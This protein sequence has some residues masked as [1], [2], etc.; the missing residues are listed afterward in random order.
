MALTMANVPDRAHSELEFHKFYGDD[1]AMHKIASFEAIADFQIKYSRDFYCFGIPREYPVARFDLPAEAMLSGKAGNFEKLSLQ[2]Q[3]GEYLAFQIA[4]WSPQLALGNLCLECG[5]FPLPIRVFVQN[6]EKYINLAAGKIKVYWC[7]IDLP[8]TAGKFSGS[9]TVNANDVAPVTIPCALTVAGEKLA[10]GGEAEDFRMSRLRWLDSE[11][12]ISHEVPVPFTALRREE[13]KI[14]LL[15]RTLTLSAVGLPAEAE[16][17]FTGSNERLC[18]KPMQLLNKPMRFVIDD[19]MQAESVDCFCDFTSENPDRIEWHSGCRFAGIDAE[20]SVNGFIEYDGFAGFDCAIKF[21]NECSVAD[22]RLEFSAPGDG[23]VGLNRHGGK[24][25]EKLLWY[26]DAN[27]GQDAFWLGKLNGGIH[28]R[29]RDRSSITP[30]TNCYYLF[31]KIVPPQA[32]DNGGIGGIKLLRKGEINAINAFSGK[33][34]IPQNKI[35]DFGF[36]MQL[37][38]YKLTEPARHLQQRFFQ[39]YMHDLAQPLEKTFTPE[40]FAQLRSEGV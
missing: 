6:Y 2:G 12:G 24:T 7:M 27:R 34:E 30:L 10:S 16:S 22:I 15:G 3:P 38:P 1:P 37:S 11:I 25:P 31:S 5:G 20:L 36:E 14:F 32:W 13:R 35:F 17:F 33:R 19:G 21:N 26:W 4:V 39:P 29:L 28:L 18:D 8:E 9:I 40:F 23:F